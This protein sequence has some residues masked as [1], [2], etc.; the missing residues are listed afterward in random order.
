MGDSPSLHIPML[1]HATE[2]RHPELG[3]LYRSARIQNLSKGGG[4]MQMM[5]EDKGAMEKWVEEVPAL[6][7]MHLGGCDISNGDISESKPKVDYKNKVEY[8]MRTW[9]RVAS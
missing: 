7:I 9:L 4:T 6:T 2:G 5:L 8:F 3:D 1:P